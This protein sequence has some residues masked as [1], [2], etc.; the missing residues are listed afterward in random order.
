[1]K[2]CRMGV[3]AVKCSRGEFP[4]EYCSDDGSKWLKQESRGENALMKAA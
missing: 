4:S 1:M 2:R 3:N